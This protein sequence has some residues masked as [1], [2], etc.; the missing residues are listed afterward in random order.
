[1]IL[2]TLRTC[3]FDELAGALDWLEKAYND[4]D[5]LILYLNVEP[6][7]KDLRSSLFQWR[8]GTRLGRS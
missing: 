6:A 8:S 3:D 1:M 7:Y 2:Q 4:R 5:R